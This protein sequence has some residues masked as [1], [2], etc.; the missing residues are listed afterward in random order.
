MGGGGTK[1]REMCYRSKDNDRVS[2][3]PLGLCHQL[4]KSTKEN[5]QDIR[6]HLS[7]VVT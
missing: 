4:K 1:G 6:R 2:N 5:Y 7:G 3:L